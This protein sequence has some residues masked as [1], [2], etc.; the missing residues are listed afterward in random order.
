LPG[1]VEVLLTGLSPEARRRSAW[2][3]TGRVGMEKGVDIAWEKRK[4][5]GGNV[6]QKL[7]VR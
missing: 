1:S 2:T 5:R 6:V 4:G 3:A 7:K